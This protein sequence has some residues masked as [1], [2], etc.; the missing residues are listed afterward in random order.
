[1]FY[2]KYKR[3]NPNYALEVFGKLCVESSMRSKGIY[4]HTR[5][6]SCQDQNSRQ[7]L[8]DLFSC[9]IKNFKEDLKPLSSLKV[10][11]R[12]TCGCCRSKK[13]VIRGLGAVTWSW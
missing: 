4:L 11:S 12:R 9:C 1:M 8:D 7:E 6:K 2:F 5:I 3:K 10:T 13:E